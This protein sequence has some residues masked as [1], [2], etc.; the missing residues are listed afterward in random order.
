MLDIFHT[1][2]FS[3]VSLTDAINKL[4]FVP[5]RIGQSGLFSETAISTT[6]VSIEESNGILKLVAP[7][8]RGA[9]G[10]TL[11][12]GKRAVRSITVPHFEI[13][14]AIM[15]E[16]VQ[17]IRAFGSESSADQVMMKVAARMQELGQSL[18][19]TKEYARV[20]AVIGVVAYADGTSLDLFTTFGVSQETEVDFD[21]DNASPASGALRKK[22]A[23][24]LRTVATNLGGVPVTGLRAICG[25]A[26]YD[27]LIAHPEVRASYLNQIGAAELRGGY[28]AAG[29]SYGTFEFGGIVWENYRGAVGGTSFVNTDKCHI[30]PEGVPGLF[31]TVY[32][33]ADYVETVNTLGKSLYAKQYDMPNGKGVN[34]DVQTNALSYCTRPAALIKGKRT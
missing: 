11:D 3:L 33:P 7:T 31:R 28:V 12:K 21:L 5:G 27:D 34:L 4:P 16:E 6:T 15:A 2:P 26:F 20:G 17:N 1:D 25:D 14:D 24:V 23:G 19:A 10:V 30:Y 29:Q 18:E 8:L 22:C 9:P 13:N 32:A